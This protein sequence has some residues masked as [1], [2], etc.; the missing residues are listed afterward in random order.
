MLHAKALVID[1]SVAIIGSANMDMR[2]LLLNYEVGVCIYSP[3][4]IRQLEKWMMGLMNACG[5]RQPH[6]STTLTLIEGVSRLF[7]PLL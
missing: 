7:A 3:E 5:E 1:D 2:S 4:I 6:Q